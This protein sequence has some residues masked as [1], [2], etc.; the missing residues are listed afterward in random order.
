[1]VPK[2]TIIPLGADSPGSPTRRSLLSL[3]GA[4]VLASSLGALTS[5]LQTTAKKKKG[6]KKKKGGKGGGGGGGGGGRN[7]GG[8]DGYD[9]AAGPSSRPNINPAA[10]YGNTA[11]KN[12]DRIKQRENPVA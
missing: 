3:L 5:P 4:G 10:T 1:M 8:R 7:A 12:D 2:T 11:P 9:P 6:K